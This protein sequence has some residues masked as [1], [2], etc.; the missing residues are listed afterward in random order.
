M[1]SKISVQNENGVTK[2]TYDNDTYS[3]TICSN[4]YVT[5]DRK[6]TDNEE[7]VRQLLEDLGRSTTKIN[8]LVGVMKYFAQQGVIPKEQLEQT[9][10]WIYGPENN[11]LRK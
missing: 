6:T 10:E 1:E 11:K 5:L 3:Y 2:S 7:I 4:G 9:L 8:S